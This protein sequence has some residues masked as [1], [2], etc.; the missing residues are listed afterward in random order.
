MTQTEFDY[1]KRA[2]EAIEGRQ[3]A[4]RDE[5]KVLRTISQITERSAQEL[6]IKIGDKTV[7]SLAV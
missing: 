1:I 6:E 5:V 7:D 3:L 4:R 2:V